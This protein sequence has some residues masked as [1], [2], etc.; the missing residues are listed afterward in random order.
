MKYLTYLRFISPTC[1]IKQHTYVIKDSLTKN[2]L[3]HTCKIF[4]QVLAKKFRKYGPI[5]QVCKLSLVMREK[6]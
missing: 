3:K 4:S 5:S 2:D 6:N 1:E